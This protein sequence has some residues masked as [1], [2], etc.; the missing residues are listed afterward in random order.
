MIKRLRNH[1]ALALWAGDNE[2]DCAYAYWSGIPRDPNKNVI[3]RR[4]IPEL[5]EMHDFTRPYLPS[6]PYMDETAYREGP[7]YISEDHLWGP[8]D[9]YKSAFYTHSIAHFASEIGYH[10]CPAPGSLKKFLT[11]EALW[12]WQGSEEWML[13]A[14]SPSLA[15][16]SPYLYRIELM[17]KQVRELF[18]AIPE[19]LQDFAIASQA[20]Q[21]EAVK[22]FIELFRCA[23][24]RRTGLLWWN[25]VDGWPQFS[26]AV[27][28]YYGVKKLAYSFIKRSQAAVCLMFGDPANW[29]LP[30]YA[31]NDTPGAKKI[32][33]SVMNVSAGNAL[34]TQGEAVVPGDS[35]VCVWQSDFSMR[36]Q[37][38]YLITWTGDAQ[39]RNHYLIGNPP[40]DLHAY[41][42]WLK[43]AQI[44]EFE[45][46]L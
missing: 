30:L 33:Y 9:Y 7:A 25:L 23:K 26:D 27:V 18:G 12:P 5:L 13:R 11:T 45:G 41:I 15:P 24:W 10:G 36:D 38:L 1:P 16:D 39:G 31:A 40:F 3:T 28:D 19:N 35:T 14:T 17:A 20:S 32:A 29:R 44:F 6:S 46:F 43:A 2:C 42:A 37:G 22:Y 21:A 4:W 34:I 8:R